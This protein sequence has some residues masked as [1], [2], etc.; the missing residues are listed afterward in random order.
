MDS[1]KLLY[2]GQQVAVAL[3]GLAIVTNVLTWVHIALTPVAIFCFLLVFP[4]FAGGLI[5]YLIRASARTPYRFPWNQILDG[6]A[7]PLVIAAYVFVAYVFINFFGTVPLVLG[8]RNEL[9]DPALP[10][11]LMTGHA[12][13]FLLVAAGLFRATRR[14][15]KV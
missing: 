11:R 9:V 13:I 2:V 7:R 10:V 3:A 12:A 14:L 8:K 4:L 5:W 6:L 15:V 1:G